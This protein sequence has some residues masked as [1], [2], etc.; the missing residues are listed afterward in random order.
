MC[1]DPLFFDGSVYWGAHM[2]FIPEEAYLAWA[3]EPPSLG[4]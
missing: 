1:S 3:T 2:Y 4:C